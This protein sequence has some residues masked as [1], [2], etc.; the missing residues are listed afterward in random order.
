M[1]PVERAWR[2]Q[3]NQKHDVSIESYDVG[4]TN[5]YIYMIEYLQSH[6]ER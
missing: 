1:I 3:M 5:I 2:D 6:M 4:L